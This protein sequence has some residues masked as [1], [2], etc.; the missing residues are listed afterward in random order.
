MAEQND[1][2]AWR[3]QGKRLVIGD[4]DEGGVHDMI[5]MKD[6]MLCV[7]DKGIYSVQLADGVDPNRTNPAIPDV[8]Q[9][10]L[11]YGA[12]EPLVAR[13]LLQAKALLDDGA[14]PES[15]DVMRGMEIAFSL[16]K[17]L[18]S[19]NE[20]KNSFVKEEKEKNALFQAQGNGADDS[21]RLPSMERV[22]Q[23]TKQF[24]TNADHAARHLMETAQ[25][26]YSDIENKKWLKKWRVKLDEQADANE[27]LYSYSKWAWTLRNLRN[28]VDHQKPE[29]HIVVTDYKLMENGKIKPPSISY[30]HAETP[31]S[32][33]RTSRFM[34]DTLTNFLNCYDTSLALM[35]NIHAMPFAED[36]RSV[37]QIPEDKRRPGHKNIRFG[38]EIAWTK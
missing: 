26:F 8:Q 25:L 10:V 5:V 12:D 3:N 11:A 35:C 38:Y 18:A 16:A 22:E 7:K 30:A 36:K 33:M 13:T 1:P 23:R 29:D 34:A 32:E 31:L 27:F 17:E 21:L 20:L 4:D 6:R 9:K 14:L 37:V 19:L 15:I 28:A 24:I 2:F